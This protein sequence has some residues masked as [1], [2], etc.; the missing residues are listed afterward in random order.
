[1]EPGPEVFEPVG[2]VRHDGLVIPGLTGN[3]HTVHQ[4]EQVIRGIGAHLHDILDVVNLLRVHLEQ[5]SVTLFLE[6]KHQFDPVF[7]FLPMQVGKDVDRVR[8]TVEDVPEDVLNGM[9][10]HLFPAHGRIGAADA[11]KQQA[12]V[13]VD[14]RRGGD[15]GTGI[16]D[17]DL[18]LDGDGGRN[19]LDHLHVGLGHPAQEL[20]G[21][22][23]ETLGETA[24]PFGEERVERQGGFSAAGDARDHDEAVPRNLYRNVLEVV[25]FRP[26]DDDISFCRHIRIDKIAKLRIFLRIFEGCL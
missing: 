21:V 25:D 13:I 20:P 4:Q 3:L 24:L 23:G 10:L 15:G 2:Q 16:P 5:A 18:L 12:Q 14:F 9:G 22:G 6:G 17:I 26:S 19:A 1:M 8:G 11:R 7:P